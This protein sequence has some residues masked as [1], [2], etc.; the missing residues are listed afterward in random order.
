MVEG[1]SWGRV[2]LGG[3]GEG[4]VLKGQRDTG[5]GLRAFA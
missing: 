1:I 5:L 3:E 4:L 2:R